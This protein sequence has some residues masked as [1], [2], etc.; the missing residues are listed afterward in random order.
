MTMVKDLDLIFY[1]CALFGMDGH[2]V[3]QQT[4]IEVGDVFKTILKEVDFLPSEYLG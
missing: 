2:Q 4:V 1:S 3:P